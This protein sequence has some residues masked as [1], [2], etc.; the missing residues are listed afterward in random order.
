MT[1][2]RLILATLAA[3]V[4]LAA[5]APTSAGA[6]TMR[7]CPDGTM[8]ADSERCPKGKILHGPKAGQMQLGAASLAA[9]GGQGASAGQ[10]PKPDDST[11]KWRDYINGNK[12][13]PVRPKS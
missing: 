3:A 11:K 12:K 10:A 1:Y 7:K 8:V 9:P 4:S 6:V 5:F 13:P 2:N